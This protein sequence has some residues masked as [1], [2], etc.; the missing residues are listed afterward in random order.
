MHTFEVFYHCTIIATCYVISLF[1]FQPSLYGLWFSCGSTSCSE[2]H[3]LAIYSFPG[4]FLLVYM[5]V[6]KPFLSS[7]NRER[8]VLDMYTLSNLFEDFVLFSSSALFHLPSTTFLGLAH[9]AL[10]FSYH[11]K[12]M[13][14]SFFLQ[15][16]KFLKNEKKNL[17]EILD[18][19][20]TDYDT[21]VSTITT[22]KSTE[23]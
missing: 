2:L 18:N 14:S 21:L 3:I 22:T 6:E 20:S 5:Q 19:S 12:R 23:Y 15:S 16:N 7:L 10:S 1:S 8:Y 17:L 13:N 11:G 4:S 9:S